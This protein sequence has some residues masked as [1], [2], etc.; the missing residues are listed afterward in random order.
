M[1]QFLFSLVI[2]LIALNLTNCESSMKG[3]SFSK[4]L[5]PNLV[6]KYQAFIIDQWGVLHDGKELYPGSLN[7][8]KKLRDNGKKTVML[9]NSSKRKANSIAGLKKVGLDPSIYFDEIVTSGEMAWQFIESR[10]IC[11]GGFVT[12]SGG[13]TLKVILM[14]NGAD[15]EEYLTSCG[16]VVSSIE[17]ADFILARGTFCLQVGIEEVHEYPDAFDLLKSSTLEAILEACALRKLPMLVSNP[18][19]Y[20]PGSGQPMPG[21]IADKYKRKLTKEAST[22]IIK[23][24]G[25]PF[26]DV[27]ESCF[28]SL[29]IP[30]KSTICGIGDSLEH[31]IIGASA[32]GMGSIF[33][34]NGVHC[35][36]LGT[37]EGTAASAGKEKV[38]ELIFAVGRRS[39]RDPGL[40][41]PTTSVPCFQWIEE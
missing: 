35:E 33:I 13:S 15:D 9:S 10:E 5:S 41:E 12:Q 31:D 3:I 25:K 37:L 26:D 28:A 1:D 24:F 16:C 7:T 21:L 23:Y 14:G 40:C 34:E 2:L 22:P 39:G 36:S 6:S 18:D 11:K 38:S 32:A 29:G 30:D 19:F 20:R 17:E 27:Y 4:G 8:M